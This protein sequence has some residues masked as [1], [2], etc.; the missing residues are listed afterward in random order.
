M[1]M[2]IFPF[3]YFAVQCFYQVCEGGGIVKRVPWYNF[4]VNNTNK[5]CNCALRC[6][7]ISIK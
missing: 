7:L 3:H 6:L 1:N 2:F 5:Q 4:G